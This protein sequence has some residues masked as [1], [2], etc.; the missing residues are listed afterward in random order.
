M[1]LYIFMFPLAATLLGQG[2]QNSDFSLVA[3]VRHASVQVGLGVRVKTA[4][5]L[6]LQYSFGHQLKRTKHGEYWIDVPY[7]TTIS[8]RA[9][10]GSSVQ[11]A[12][13]SMFVLTPGLRY[14]VQASDRV[15]LYAVAGGGFGAFRHYNVAAGPEVRVTSS[16]T[17]KG[18]LSAGGGLDVRLSRLLSLRFEV[19]DYVSGRGLSGRDGRNHVF[20]LGGIAFHH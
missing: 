8:S 15:A 14:K 3:G 1:R 19:R 12:T 9:E 6:A 13:S 16:S 7:I 17:A 11:T 10:V 5:S 4:A 20:A 18:A 2:S